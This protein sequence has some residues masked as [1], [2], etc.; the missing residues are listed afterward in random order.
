MNLNVIIERIGNGYIVTEKDGSGKWFYASLEKFAE[1]WIIAPLKEQDASIR[2]HSVPEQ[3]FYLKLESDLF[4]SVQKE[5]PAIFSSWKED[6]IRRSAQRFMEL[7]L[8]EITEDE[9]EAF[10]RTVL[11]S[12]EELT[13]E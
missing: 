4:K 7:D 5:Y 13:E 3:P 10:I 6:L 1:T 12:Y 2:H 8:T 9:V 11:S